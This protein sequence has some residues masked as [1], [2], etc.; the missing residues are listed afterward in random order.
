MDFRFIEEVKKNSK[1]N[2]GPVADCCKYPKLI[3]G[4]GW[5]SRNRETGSANISACPGCLD[6]ISSYRTN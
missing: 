4:K 1:K 5:R 3:E 2:P 6:G